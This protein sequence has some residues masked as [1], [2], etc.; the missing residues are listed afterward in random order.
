MMDYYIKINENPRHRVSS[1][2]RVSV[3]LCRA[4]VCEC[5]QLITNLITPVSHNPQA[6]QVG[7]PFL[8]GAFRTIT[9]TAM[10]CVIS[11]IAF[12]SGRW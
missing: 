4:E 10:V 12:W 9:L 5:Y 11:A 6:P 8:T 1:D 3:S 2:V 7:S